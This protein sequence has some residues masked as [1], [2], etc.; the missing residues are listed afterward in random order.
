M[1]GDASEA[2]RIVMSPVLGEYQRTD[3]EGNFVL[4]R[5]PASSVLEWKTKSDGGGTTF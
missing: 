4:S 3:M 1:G 5:N 2:C